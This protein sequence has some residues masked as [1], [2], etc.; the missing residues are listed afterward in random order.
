MKTSIDDISAEVTISVRIPRGAWME[1]ASAIAAE[2]G[3]GLASRQKETPP[4]Q[5]PVRRGAPSP[6]PN[7]P[8]LVSTAEVARRLSVSPSMVRLW[9]AKPGFP[10]VRIG[11]CIRFR[12]DDVLQWI[13]ERSRG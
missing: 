12:F 8:T 9:S 6:E 7:Q 2:V 1:L 4:R 13:E 10:K 3:P 11:R 5:E